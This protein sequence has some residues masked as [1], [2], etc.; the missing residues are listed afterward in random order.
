MAAKKPKK[1]V[2][3]FKQALLSNTD[4]IKETDNEN[5]TKPVEIAVHEDIVEPQIREKIKILADFEGIT[6][7]E[8]IN[9][10]LNHF[11]RLKGLQLEE[12]LKKKK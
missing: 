2:K 1:N 8:M 10:A 5:Y 12:A 3:Q 7:K 9:K 6:E 11:L 4:F